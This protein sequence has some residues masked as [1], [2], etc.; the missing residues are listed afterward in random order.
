MADTQ[1]F[2]VTG[3]GDIAQLTGFKTRNNNQTD[4]YAWIGGILFQW[5]TISFSTSTT[6][7]AD[8]VIFKDRVT[9]AIPFPSYCFSVT[10]TPSC[11]GSSY[12]G[13]RNSILIRDA[14]NTQFRYVFNSS[15]I[16]AANGVNG[17]YWV[18][19]GK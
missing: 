3:S 9:G 7:K 2:T 18:A 16:D 15:D 8:T 17:F 5:G 4:G 1:L 11:A 10:A 19:I 13:S 6:H 12:T 14:T